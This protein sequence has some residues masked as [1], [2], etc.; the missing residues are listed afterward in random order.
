MKETFLPLP[1]RLGHPCQWAWHNPEA[2][3]VAW[4]L[5]G[6]QARGDPMVQVA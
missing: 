6:Q 1:Q 2:M 4:G 5:G 3:V